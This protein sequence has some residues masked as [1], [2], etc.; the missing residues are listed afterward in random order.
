MWCTLG[1]SRWHFIFL[2]IYPKSGPSLKGRNG[3]GHFSFHIPVSAVNYE[4]YGQVLH[5]HIQWPRSWSLLL[6]ATRGCSQ[7]LHMH[8]Q[9]PRSWSLLLMAT[10]GCSQVLHAHTVVPGAAGLCCSWLLEA[11]VK[12]CT[13]T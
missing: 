7:V 8:I 11:A 12:Y 5:M 2:Q 6:M 13:C 1:N 4:G 9:W 3:L 10:R